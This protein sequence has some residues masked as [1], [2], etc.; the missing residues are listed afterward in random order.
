MKEL[1]DKGRHGDFVFQWQGICNARIKY[2]V[3]LI[4]APQLHMRLTKSLNIWR[5]LSSLKWLNSS[6][7]LVSNFAP[8]WSCIENNN[9][10]FR[11][12]KLHWYWIEL[13]DRRSF[14]YWI[15][16]TVLFPNTKKTETVLEALC[17]ARKFLVF[18]C[19]SSLITGNTISPQ[20]LSEILRRKTLYNLMKKESF[21]N[22]H[23]SGRESNHNSW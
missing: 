11:C 3:V 2:L 20:V 17:S 12:E 7:S 1:S 16:Q 10:C 5:N 8:I 14:D 18:I 22:L 6:R 23:R 15:S 4:S 13:L 21:Q 9:L 19:G